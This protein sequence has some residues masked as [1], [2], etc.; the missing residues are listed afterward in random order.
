MDIYVQQG[1]VCSLMRL[2]LSNIH[3]S[4]EFVMKKWWMNKNS[5]QDTLYMQ[6]DHPLHKSRLHKQQLMLQLYSGK[7][8]LLDMR[9]KM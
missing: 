8:T 9:Y 3:S 7:L 5:P 1:M 6:F 4:I 2:L